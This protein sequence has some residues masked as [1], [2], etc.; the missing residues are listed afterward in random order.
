MNAVESRIERD[1]CVDR[2]VGVDGR[3]VP[4]EGS[5]SARKL[6]SWQIRQTAWGNAVV[7]FPID[8][9]RRWNIAGKSDPQFGIDIQRD[10]LPRSNDQV[11]FMGEVQWKCWKQLKPD[12]GKGITNRGP[13][14]QTWRHRLPRVLTPEATWPRQTRGAGPPPSR[15]RGSASREAAATTDAL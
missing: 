14:G 3:I 6:F 4:E 2:F 9:I 11:V 1:L 8:W 12:E 13:S 10:A 15:V 5:G 7:T